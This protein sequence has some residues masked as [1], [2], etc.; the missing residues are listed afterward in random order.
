ML[1]HTTSEKASTASLLKDKKKDLLCLLKMRLVMSQGGATTL[2]PRLVPYG[3]WIYRAGSFDF[4]MMSRKNYN[5]TFSADEMCAPAR[6]NGGV[7]VS[8]STAGYLRRRSLNAPSPLVVNLPTTLYMSP[9]QTD[10]HIIVITRDVP[11]KKAPQ[12]QHQNCP[13]RRRS[14]ALDPIDPAAAGRT[15]TTPAP[16]DSRQKMPMVVPSAIASRR[17]SG[18]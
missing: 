17:W 9:P 8:H 1:A 15:M 5:L 7:A 14:S 10:E 16:D 6:E 12:S 3:D 4:G 13:S 11:S 18:P 2:N